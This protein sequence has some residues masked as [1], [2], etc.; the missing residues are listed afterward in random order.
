MSKQRLAQKFIAHHRKTG[1]TDQEIYEHLIE[2]GEDEKSATQL[3]S[4]TI[5]TDKKE[6]YKLHNQ[7]LIILLGLLALFHVIR[8]ISLFIQTQELKNLIYL[9]AFPVISA[10]FAH[11]V[12]RYNAI[13]YR[14]CG[15]VTLLIFLQLIPDLT[16]RILMPINLILSASVV[17]LSFYLHSRMFPGFKPKRRKKKEAKHNS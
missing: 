3:I 6:K 13:I 15:V 4:N 16:G 17:G 7:I 8:V 1:K 2:L 14:V 11:E 5:T 12:S 10:F 9:F